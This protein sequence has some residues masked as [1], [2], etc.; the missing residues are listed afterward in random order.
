MRATLD[1]L[2]TQ[3]APRQI[4]TL[5]NVWSL[6]QSWRKHAMRA[7]WS[8][9]GL[10]VVAGPGGGGDQRAAR[11]SSPQWETASDETAWSERQPQV[12]P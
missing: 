9:D 1:T 6:D 2:T 8:S 7:G 12:S 4:V 10:S 5:P 11:D 3:V